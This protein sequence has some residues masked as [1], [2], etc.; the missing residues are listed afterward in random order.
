MKKPSIGFWIIAAALLIWNAFGCYMYMVDVT[1][2]DARYAEV[3]GDAMLAIRDLYPAWAIAAYALAVWGG[4]LAAALL[5]LRRRVC[6]PLFLV[7]LVAAVICF[8]PV[9]VSTPLRESGGETFWV[10]PVI[11]VVIG[12]FQVWYARRK[13][14]DGILR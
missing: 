13:K 9:F 1:A 2:S 11:V 12:L 10:M 8:I 7:S 3:Y 14:A 5:L 6:V 4:L